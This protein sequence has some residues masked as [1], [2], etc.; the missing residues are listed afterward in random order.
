M[1]KVQDGRD[2]AFFGAEGPLPEDLKVI[3]DT[4][5]LTHDA[6]CVLTNYLIISAAVIT[7]KEDGG[8]IRV[9]LG[10]IQKIVTHKYFKGE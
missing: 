10:M 9:V 4:K 1:C 6:Y 8:N 2:V 7:L 3:V 5:K